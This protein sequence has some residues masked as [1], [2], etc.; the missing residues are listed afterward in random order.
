M[1]AAA[2]GE[3]L[4]AFYNSATGLTEVYFDADGSDDAGEILVAQIDIVG[5]NVVN[6]SEANFATL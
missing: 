2:A 1:T 5:A 6:L 3:V 4:V